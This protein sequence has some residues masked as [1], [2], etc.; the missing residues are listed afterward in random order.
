VNEPPVNESEFTVNLEK[1][2]TLTDGKILTGA[3][4]DVL[5]SANGVEVILGRVDD[6]AGDGE[7]AARTIFYP[8]HRVDS[9]EAVTEIVRMLPGGRWTTTFGDEG[10]R[11]SSEATSEGGEGVD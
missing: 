9:I 10:T 4:G 8:W 3:R 5:A 7:I 6:P 11:V 1:R 2:V